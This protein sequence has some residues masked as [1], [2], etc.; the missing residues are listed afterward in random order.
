M[1]LTRVVGIFL[2]VVMVGAWI[3]ASG[4]SSPVSPRLPSP[5]QFPS[6]NPPVPSPALP[7][8]SVL[9]ISRLTVTDLPP[10]SGGF[11]YDVRF[12]LTETSGRTGATI[13]NIASIVGGD[14]D[15][16][17]PACWRVA[18]RVEPGST[19]DLFEGNRLGYCA[20]SPFSRVE[21]SVVSVVV[22]FTDDEGGIG[23]AKASATIAKR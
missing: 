10:D 5:D 22:T 12:L 11:S 13:Q 16:T 4:C 21:A 7:A 3:A 8:L 1:R 23:T 2:T 17:G 6:S 18:I 14:T 15:N 9:E 20:P 19:L